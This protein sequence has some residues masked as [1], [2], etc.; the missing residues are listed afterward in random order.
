MG[1]FYRELNA[2]KKDNEALWNGDFGGD[3]TP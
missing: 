2:L 3:Y 1:D